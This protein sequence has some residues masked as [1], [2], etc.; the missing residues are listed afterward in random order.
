[1]QHLADDMAAEGIEAKTLT[2]KLK[3]TAFEVRTRATTLPGHVHTAEQMLPPLLKLLRAELPVEIR[4]MGVR[5]SALRTVHKPGDAL[6]AAGGKL[7]ALQRMILQGRQ[8]QQPQQQDGEQHAKQH[9]GCDGWQNSGTVAAQEEQQHAVAAAAV[10]EDI[11]NDERLSADGY[12]TDDDSTVMAWDAADAAA[13]AAA[14]ESGW[15]S[16]TPADQLKAP[17]DSAAAAAGWV[18][19]QPAGLAA[20]QEQ[21]QPQQLRQQEEWQQ[22]QQLSGSTDQLAAE[23]RMLHY[24]QQGQQQRWQ[25]QDLQHAPAAKRARLSSQQQQDMSAIHCQQQH[26]QQQQLGEP[27]LQ[28]HVWSSQGDL[29]MQQSTALQE[30][31]QQQQV[32]AQLAPPLPAGQW[33]QA[34]QLPCAGK[35]QPPHHLDTGQRQQQQHNLEVKG[36]QVP[37]VLP[38]TQATNTQPCTSSVS[39]G[40]SHMG[41]DGAG[42]ACAGVGSSSSERRSK[43]STWACLICTYSGNKPVMLRCEMCETPKGSSSAAPAGQLQSTDIAAAGGGAATGMPQTKGSKVKAVREQKGRRG[44]AGAKTADGKQLTL[45]QVV[46]PATTRS[47]S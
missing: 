29:H 14:D 32:T 40:S 23:I 19:Q 15:C 20:Q 30:P 2:L 26:L 44:G 27:N 33:H 31:Q 39:F 46:L 6:A 16:D 4:L 8:Q 37:A 10:A 5:G 25:Q 22:W 11:H 24:Q 21:Q 28:Q 34:S 45:D 43:G 42:M 35:Q 47:R 17:G 3:T 18:Q 1:M 13:A 7:N 12:A 41:G 9:P 36:R 38:C